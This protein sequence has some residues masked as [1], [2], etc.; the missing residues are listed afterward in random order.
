MLREEI[1][2]KNYIST[3]H[4]WET[5][6]RFVLELPYG[7]EK[8]LLIIDEFPYMCHGNKSIPSILQNLWDM[9]LRDK[10]VML[11]LCGSA[12]SFMEKELLAEKNPLY[13]RATGIYKMQEMGFYDAAK[14]FPNYSAKDK[15][16]SYAILG[17]IPHYLCQ[18]NSNLSL[19]ENIKRNILT[20][21]CILYSEVEFLLHQELRETPIYNSIIEA[22]ALGNTKL[23]AIS[24]KS[25]VEDISKTSVYLKNLM[26]LGIVEREFSVDAGIKEHGNS[27]RGIYRLTDNYFRF[28]Y[29]FCFTNFSQL[30]DGDVDGVYEYLVKP[31]LQRFASI[32]F[33]SVCHEFVRE[34]QKKN[35]LPFRYAKMGRWMGKTTVRDESMPKGVRIAES[36]IDLLCISA[37]AKQYLLGEY[38][39][40][41]SPFSYSEY[42]DTLAKLSSLKKESKFY[43]ALFSESG[44]DEK[45]IAEASGNNTMLCT[46]EQIVNY[47]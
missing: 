36:E 2:A 44:F 42:L 45:I 20:K 19:E 10:N 15:L 8:K 34:M 31:M 27:N 28:W 29:A 40:K 37:N 7:E 4:D 17:G 14:F 32:T 33:E 41:T 9:E 22:V 5:A 18:W 23:N 24:Q 47:K 25:L 35:A 12:M 6:F 43:Y 30:E 11:V 1:P 21:G 39:L 3:S 46:L 26:E 13:G 16:L 38:K